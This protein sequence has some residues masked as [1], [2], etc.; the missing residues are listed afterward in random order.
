MIPDEPYLIPGALSLELIHVLQLPWD[1]GALSPFGH[2]HCGDTRLPAQERPGFAFLSAWS[3]QFQCAVAVGGE[4]PACCS[5][6]L[7]PQ[8]R[9]AITALPRDRAI[10]S[11]HQPCRTRGLQCCSHRRRCHSYCL[12]KQRRFGRGVC[13]AP[14][15]G[16]DT[17]G[18]M[19]AQCIPKSVPPDLLPHCP[20]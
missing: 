4:L 15:A 5:W 16:R 20:P 9:W 6:G 8:E 17:G 19:G 3:L 7:S 1:Q 2:G 18:V 14:K 12:T 10:G 13:A 11:C